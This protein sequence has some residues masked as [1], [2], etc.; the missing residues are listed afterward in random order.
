MAMNKSEKAEMDRLRHDLALARAMRW[1]DYPRPA[2][3]TREDI[4]A[5]LIDG[6][7]KYGSPQKVARG[8]FVFSHLGGFSDGRV[9]YGCSDGIH[10]SAEGDATTTKQMGVMYATKRDA[11]HVLRL[12]LT[13]KCAE[14]LARVDRMIAEEADE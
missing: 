4:A 7:M 8:W 5:N 10:H 12:E 3:M 9:S 11:L 6:G 14:I 13:E 1:P 2:P